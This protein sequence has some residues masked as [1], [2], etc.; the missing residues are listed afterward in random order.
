MPEHIKYGGK[1][2]VK[3][4]WI[5]FN[6]I[7]EWEYV[8]EGFCVAME[9]P[10][11]KG[12]GKEPLSVNSYRKISL[13]NVIGKVFEQLLSKRLGCVFTD[14]ALGSL[15]GGGKPNSTC[16]GTSLILQEA[17]S[18]MVENSQTVLVAQLDARSAFDVVWHDGLFLKMYEMGIKAKAWRILKQWYE[19]SVSCVCVSG[20]ISTPY[21]LRQGNRQ[22]GILSMKLYTLFVSDL[23][24]QLEESKMG[25]WNY[26]GCPCYADDLALVAI[27]P[28]TLQKM[29]NIVD[30][31]ARKWRYSF[32]CS[33]SVALVIGRKFGNDLKFNLA[34][35][36]LETVSEAVHLGVPLSSKHRLSGALEAKISKGRRSVRAMCGFNS[37]QSIP[38]PTVLGRLY[39]SVIVP[40]LLFGCEVTVMLDGDRDKL[41]VFHRSVARRIQGLSEKTPNVMCMTQLGWLSL[42]ATIDIKCLMFLRTLFMGATP[43]ICHSISISRLTQIPY[44]LVNMTSISPMVQ[45][46]SV[47]A[48]Y[49]LL[50]HVNY[51]LDG[52]RVISKHS[53]K[54]IV[55][56]PC[57][58]GNIHYRNA[59]VFCIQVVIYS[60]V[61]LT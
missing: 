58:L 42:S 28:E 27:Y 14:S 44:G 31:Y 21:P 54:E 15:E 22:G 9:V 40:S 26:V 48:K 11:F 24:R 10:V 7:R 45:L 3:A 51:W 57:I 43:S 29:I 50:N 1:S 53:W 25:C 46:Y 34:D 52:G 12:K 37:S 19:K 18:Y 20:N 47:C 55:Y 33:K 38:M 30:S 5:L 39:W 32:N 59:F 41:D 61:L 2:L 8:P 4:L 49:G 60:L 35:E 6:S 16:L 17:V 56:K 23:L 36:A 13:M